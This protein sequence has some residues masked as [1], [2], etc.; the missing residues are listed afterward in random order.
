MTTNQYWLFPLWTYMHDFGT[1]LGLGA[2]IPPFLPSFSLLPPIFGLLWCV[3]GLYISWTL[4]QF[5]SDQRGARSVWLPTLVM[6]MLQ[7]VVTIIVSY[8]VWAGW[9]FLTVPLPLHFVI[10]FVLVRK[11]NQTANSEQVLFD[12]K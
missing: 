7:I 11:R 4:R 6:L 12:K 8:I 1:W 9:P 10:V 2:I 3:V 5:Y